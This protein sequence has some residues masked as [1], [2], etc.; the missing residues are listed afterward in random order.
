VIAWVLV[1]WSPNDFVFPLL[2]RLMPWLSLVNGWKRGHDIM[3]GVADAQKLFD[4]SIVMSILTGMLRGWGGSLLFPVEAS[5][6]L[7]RVHNDLVD[8][9]SW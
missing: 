9:P 8:P 5:W 7:K 1:F 6:R 3:N 2:T 4:Q